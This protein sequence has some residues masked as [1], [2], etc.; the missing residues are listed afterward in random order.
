[1]DKY[2]YLKIAA[3]ALVPVMLVTMSFKKNGKGL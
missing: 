3:T 1:M 2:D